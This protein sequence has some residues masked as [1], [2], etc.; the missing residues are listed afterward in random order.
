LRKTTTG[1]NGQTPVS[2]N[3]SM[4]NTEEKPLGFIG[5]HHAFSVFLGGLLFCL[6]A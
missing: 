1:P 4:M 2:S 6:Q 5:V 3:S